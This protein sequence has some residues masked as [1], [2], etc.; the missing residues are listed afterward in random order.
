M[1]IEYCVN[2]ID[3]AEMMKNLIMKGTSG[4]PKAVVNQCSAMYMNIDGFKQRMAADYERVYTAWIGDIC[5][6]VVSVINSQSPDES[7]K[8]CSILFIYVDEDYRNIGV[9]SKLI[10]KCLEDCKNNSVFKLSFNARFSEKR[11]ICLV[12]NHGFRPEGYI[13][14]G[15]KEF[16]SIVFEIMP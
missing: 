2:C 9:A 7:K 10:Q 11:M 14:M 12:I 4:A 3:K 15:S 16:D 6:G 1:E 8:L 5:I 13:N